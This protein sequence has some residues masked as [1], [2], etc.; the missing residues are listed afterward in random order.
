MSEHDNQAPV[1]QV[2]A[3]AENT[4]TQ[5]VSE[6]SQTSQE[7]PEATQETQQPETAETEVSAEDKANEKLYAGKFKSTEDLE[8]SYQEL[9]KRFSKETSEKAHLTRTLSDAFTPAP[10][11]PE[12]AYYEPATPDPVVSELT[13]KVAVMEF[14]QRHPDADGALMKE[15]LQSD[16]YVQ[17]ITGNEGKLEYAYLKALAAGQ[18]KAVAEAG[19]KSA[20]QAQAKFA[21]KQAAQVETAKQQAEP[22]DDNQELTQEQIRDKLRSDKGFEEILADKK[23]YPASDYMRSR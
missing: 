4:P 17:Q 7:A 10:A 22:A 20:E 18:Q 1:E 13:K 6:A 21:E 23:K 2:P 12:E 16:P 15:I 9:E 5:E 19:K 11:E 3:A 14:A 8:R